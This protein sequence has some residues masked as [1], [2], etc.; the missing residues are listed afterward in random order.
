[1]KLQKPKGTKDVLPG[2][3]A[4]WQTLE[5][6]FRKLAG[7][8]GY[9]E[10]R[11]PTFESVEV[12]E[13][14][15]GDTSEIVEK[16][17]FRFQDMG[18]RNVALKPESTAPAMRMLIENGL[19]APGVF[20]RLYY[21]SS[22]H[23]R[24]ENPQLGR[25]REHH[26]CGV[27]LV[28]VSS[29]HADA[30][31]IEIF[32]RYLEQVGVPNPIVSINTLGDAECRARYQTDILSH[33]AP[34]V[35]AQEAEE[36]ARIEKN[37]LRLLDRKDAELQELKASAPSILSFLSPESQARFDLLQQLLND[38][39][40]AFKVDDRIVRGLDYYT[41]VVFECLR[42][43]LG[44]QS[45]IG[46]GGRYDNL[47][48]ELG[49]SSLPSV[50]FGIG[51][52][53]VIIVLEKHGKLPEAEPVSVF[54]VAQSD[55]ARPTVAQIARELRLTGISAVYDL[56]GNSLK[57]QM[58]QADKIGCRAVIV[59]GEN[60]IETGELSLKWMATG[61]QVPVR[62]DELASVLK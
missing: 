43:E 26:Q 4:V 21:I 56:E 38:A 24:Q 23:F 13:R 10:I 36:R 51:M 1:M 54:V 35:S 14:S 46:A 17:M 57:S 33:F 45:A 27:E 58:R 3:S 28:G 12:F 60:E 11:T 2:E 5:A 53:R 59:I 34:F 48:K 40:V 31:A 42:D 32:G 47:I 22:P 30:E 8:Y 9:Q 20:Q 29:I 7:T 37:P 41:E 19:A 16:Q 6:Q 15:A 39:G 44:S 62:R 61:E 52:E 25:L 18:G 50:G 49:G 55:V